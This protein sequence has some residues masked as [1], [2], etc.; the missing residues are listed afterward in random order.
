MTHSTHTLNLGDE[1]Q[2]VSAYRIEPNTEPIG[3]PFIEHRDVVAAI[4]AH[5]VDAIALAA[6]Y[7]EHNPNFWY[8][9][10][11]NEKG[12]YGEARDFVRDIVWGRYL[13][14][15]ASKS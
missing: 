10:F 14:L 15:R 8:E 9:K 13:E 5:E 4:Q 2:L 1:Y 3:G 12:Y 6:I 7:F 11:C